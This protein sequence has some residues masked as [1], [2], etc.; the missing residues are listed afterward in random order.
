MFDPSD[1]RNNVGRCGTHATSASHDAGES[2]R[3]ST[4]STRTRPEVGVTNPSNTDNNVLFPDP[5]GPTKATR[6][7]AGTE[8]STSDSAGTP[9]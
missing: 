4:P 8:R 3:R 6:E 2:E 5:L 9:S 7:P 1:P